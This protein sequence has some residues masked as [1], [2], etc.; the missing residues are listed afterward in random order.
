MRCAACVAAAL[1]AA[2]RNHL[3]PVARLAPHIPQVFPNWFAV[4][5]ADAQHSTAVL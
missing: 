2:R 5:S 3:V 4:Q 1:A